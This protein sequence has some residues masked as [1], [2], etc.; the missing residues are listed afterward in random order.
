MSLTG[1]DFLELVP[2]EGHFSLLTYRSSR[3]SR[4]PF[5]IY[6]LLEDDAHSAEKLTLYIR[7]RAE[8]EPSKNASGV[9]VTVPLPR[10]VQR[11][12]CET[13]TPS[14]EGSLLSSF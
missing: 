10:G 9:E 13:D 3:A 6:P 1:M 2:P 8:Y 12:H 11:V 14:G 7:L 5:R 4:P